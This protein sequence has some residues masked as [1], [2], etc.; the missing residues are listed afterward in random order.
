MASGVVALVR[1]L[2]AGCPSIF[3]CIHGLVEKVNTLC[4]A[5]NLEDVDLWKHWEGELEPSKKVLDLLL[6]LLSLIDIQV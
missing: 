3:Y 2:P 4:S 1:Y 6:R 5:V